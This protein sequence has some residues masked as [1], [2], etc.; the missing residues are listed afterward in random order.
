VQAYDGSST[1]SGYGIGL[2]SEELSRYK[3]L[4]SYVEELKNNT[5]GYN[6]AQV[7]YLTELKTA[8]LALGAALQEVDRQYEGVRQRAQ[9]DADAITQQLRGIFGVGTD[10]AKS[11]GQRI[12]ELFKSLKD[13]FLDFAI[14]NPIKKW[15]S[16]SLT[17]L[18]SRGS[19][20]L[21]GALTNA[22]EK[23]TQLLQITNEAAT[24]M[25]EA[26]AP[27]TDRG[28][29]ADKMNEAAD[30]MISAADS[31]SGNKG[32]G[33][34]VSGQGGPYQPTSAVAA[35]MEIDRARAIAGVEKLSRE[36]FS[37][38]PEVRNPPDNRNQNTS[39]P[40][41][42]ADIVVLGRRR[43][44]RSVGYDQALN[45][46]GGIFS[47]IAQNFTARK[48][49]NGNTPI[50]AGFAD[51]KEAFSGKNKDV[52]K[53]IDGVL[54]ISGEVGKAFTTFVSLRDTLSSKEGLNTSDTVA[55][56]IA[57]A[58]AGYQLGSNFGPEAGAIGAVV[59]GVAGF[60]SDI[61]LKKPIASTT[62]VVGA[63]GLASVGETN[64]VGNGDTRASNAMAQ[65]G[66]DLFN[67]FANAFNTDLR[68]GNYGRFGKTKKDTFYSVTGATDRRGRP[69]G[70][71]GVDYVYASD[72][73][74]LEGFALK[75][76]LNRGQFPGL[77]PTLQT[78][79]R[80][81][82]STTVQGIQSDLQIGQ[83]YDAFIDSAKKGSQLTKTVQDLGKAYDI[84]RRQGVALGLSETQLARARNTLLKSYKDE[85]NY[86]VNQEI[87]KIKDPLLASYNDLLREYRNAV[88][89]AQAVGGD[90]TKV[91]ELYN[92]KR[93]QL[94]K[95]GAAAATDAL[96]TNAKAILDQLTASS[97]SVLSPTT[98]FANASA[99][100]Y[101]LK[102]QIQSGN[103]TNADNLGAYSQS[104]LSTGR[105]LFRSSS[106]YFSIFND[107]TAFLKTI[108]DGTYAS[109]TAGPTT[110]SNLP[111]LPGISTIVDELAHQNDELLGVTQEV[112]TA[113]VAGNE[114]NASLLQSLVDGQREAL[115]RIYG[116]G[117]PWTYN[118][119]MANQ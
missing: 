104:F 62:V 31:F 60:L 45:S 27:I 91:E 75:T 85:F 71:R 4:A 11:F 25:S 105:D 15:L 3:E 63:N 9:D 74:D 102:A 57:G 24:V 50:K 106:D 108:S 5:L 86:T 61:L 87:L 36:Y 35:S 47:R 66:A 80:N 100:Y 42:E 73:N 79:G 43:S 13:S 33:G 109:T 76:Q 21:S 89:D 28:G 14:F 78:V 19:P 107:V 84:L 1:L 6:D 49:E 40:D 97:E 46:V 90:L 37:Q 115:D 92:L 29:A 18:Y 95:D 72:G 110:A 55:S 26:L 23:Q 51:I 113:I 44:D 68:P 2:N 67:N 88:G 32:Y 22:N 12:K 39:A 58:V 103:T 56:T 112:G 48:D 8:Q 20:G 7:K 93:V 98:A 38:P 118:Y 119:R 94:A 81:T 17:G 10:T 99:N 34:D 117:N 52:G 54:K 77:S 59:G 69:T 101:E 64:R 96:V 30:K 116:V 53:A 82:K 65:A 16:D 41:T 114:T 111:A 70:V 83:N